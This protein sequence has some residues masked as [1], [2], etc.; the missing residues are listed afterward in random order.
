MIRKITHSFV[1]L[2]LLL[3]GGVSAQPRFTK[4][5]DPI[6]EPHDSQAPK[7]LKQI[8]LDQHLDTAI[9]PTLAFRDEE[10]KPV[11][12]GQYFGKRP[13]ILAFVYYECPMLC[14][15][16]LNGL[17]GAVKV[18]SF[19]AGQDFDVVTVSFNPNDKPELA[20]KKKENYLKAYRREN[21][22]NGWHFL[23]GDSTSIAAITNEAGFRYMYDS[24]SHQYAHAS[25]IMVLTPEGRISK[26]FYGIE[27]S[28][29]DLK[30]GLM[31]ASGN[32]IGSPVDQL[33]LY[34]YHYDPM[35][36]KYGTVVMNIMKLGGILTIIAIIAL[37]LFMRRRNIKL[38][39]LRMQSLQMGGTT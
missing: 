33:L 14:T 15:Q 17:M 38:E 13:V 35:T 30:F 23:T 27:Y 7:I 28:P 39:Q 26:Y 5:M 4:P 21:T 11:Q 24:L 25:G 10:G 2:A 36:G 8:G 34:C 20:K 1:L 37:F 29:K 32:K 22:A 6:D 3:A 19:N 18:L 31:E 12:I 9:S 16:V